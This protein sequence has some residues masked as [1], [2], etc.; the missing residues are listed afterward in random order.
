MS[1]FQA[2]SRFFTSCLQHSKEL[3]RPLLFYPLAARPQGQSLKVAMNKC[4]AV[5]GLAGFLGLLLDGIY[6]GIF[7][8]LWA[9]VRDVDPS[10]KHH[11]RC[12]K[13]DA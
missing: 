8:G 9:S 1:N 13:N 2:D 4:E 7:F 6:P 10:P 5:L 12:I 11:K 3:S